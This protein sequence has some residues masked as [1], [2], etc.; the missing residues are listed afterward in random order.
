MNKLKRSQEIR[1]LPETADLEFIAKKCSLIPGIFVNENNAIDHII[2]SETIS[3]G[4][5]TVNGM[6]REIQLTKINNNGEETIVSYIQK[7][8]TLYSIDEFAKI[9]GI[10][11]STLRR[12]DNDETFI[13]YK[14]PSGHRRY[15]DADI[16][17]LKNKMLK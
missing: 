16:Q 14:T 5:D 17:R 8:E 3:G 6:P 9:V 7:S 4:A 12:W 10:S 2:I 1:H 15:T 13:S 11:K